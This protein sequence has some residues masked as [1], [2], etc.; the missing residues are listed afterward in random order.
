MDAPD[1]LSRQM[2]S[3]LTWMDDDCHMALVAVT[4]CRDHQCG[5]VRYSVATDNTSCEFATVIASSVWE[6]HSK[7]ET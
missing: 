2:L 4:P 3:H 5:V 6:L 7:E 1:E